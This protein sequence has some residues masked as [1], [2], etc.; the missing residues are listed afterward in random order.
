MFLN[1]LF[2][3]VY[4]AFTQKNVPSSCLFYDDLCLIYDDLFKFMIYQ[5]FNGDFILFFTCQSETCV[6][7]SELDQVDDKIWTKLRI[8][9]IKFNIHSVRE[10]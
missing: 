6:H 10:N 1:K 7:D 2:L 4:S 9:I 3:V 5:G 8:D